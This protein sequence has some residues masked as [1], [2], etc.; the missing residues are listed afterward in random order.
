MAGVGDEICGR[1]VGEQS[2]DTTAACRETWLSGAWEGAGGGAVRGAGEGAA[3]VHVRR[4]IRVAE[5]EWKSNH[6]TGRNQR[7]QT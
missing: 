6:V 5:V 2:M 4:S 7:P 3:P 1:F